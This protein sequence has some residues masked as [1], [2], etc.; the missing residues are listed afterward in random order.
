M[1]L[2]LQS[3]DM[4]YQKGLICNT[5]Q[6]WPCALQALVGHIFTV[7]SLWS[8][9]QENAPRFFTLCNFKKPTSGVMVCTLESTPTS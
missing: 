4:R 9:W 1:L 7:K 8:F 6:R 2:E 3:P 5:S